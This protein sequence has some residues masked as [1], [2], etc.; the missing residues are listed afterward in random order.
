MIRKDH[1][2]DGYIKN[3]YHP[4]VYGVGYLGLGDYRKKQN[5]LAYKTW[6]GMM[7][8]SYDK[9]YHSNKPSYKNC[10]VHTDWH[11]FQVFAEWYTHN[12]SYGLGYELDKDLLV[13]GN[14]VYSES[15]CCLIPR[16][17]NAM[18][19]VEYISKNNLAIGA[20]NKGNRYGVAIMKNGKISYLGTYATEREASDAYVFEKEKYV[21]SFHLSFK[22]K[23][24]SE[25]I[26]AIKNWKVII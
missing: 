16:S 15:T 21:N 18:I 10:S 20:C 1:I 24:S 17:L 22:G 8:R 2:K 23:L 3:P 7:E 5:P 13:K 26:E 6:S 14:K 19:S 25:V 9:K 12:E 4:R 11:N